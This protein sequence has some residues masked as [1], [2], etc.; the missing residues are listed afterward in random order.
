MNETSFDTTS[1]LTAVGLGPGDPEWI[2]VKA[3]RAIE[4]ARVVFAPRSRDGDAS[5]ALRIAEPWLRPEQPII[6]LALPMTRDPDLLTP[7]WEA[8]A[9]QIAAALTPGT[10]GVYLLLGDPL[11]YGTFTYL[12]RELAQRHPHIQVSVVPGVTSFAAAAARAGVVL[13]TT[14][15]RVAILPAS[16]ETDAASLQRLLADFETVILMKVGNVLPRVL[17]ALETLGLLDA[18]VYVERVGMPE[19]RIVEN[20]HT[21][22]GETTPRP[23]LSLLIVRRSHRA[24]ARLP[25][26]AHAAWPSVSETNTPSE[27]DAPEAP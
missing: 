10:R 7:A 26:Q 19:E 1:F 3:V 22:R 20:L 13:A 2:T 8:A 14:S 5:L 16:Y 25:T 6:E 12:W 11:L 27:T 17:D 18:A 15:E 23:Y 9:D 21:L 24:P 4:Q